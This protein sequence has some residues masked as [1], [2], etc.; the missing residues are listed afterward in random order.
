MFSSANTDVLH[1][2]G[3]SLW[4]SEVF[5]GSIQPAEEQWED[6]PSNDIVPQDIVQAGNKAALHKLVQ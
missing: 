6:M 2:E 5:E 3:Y 4:H 1:G